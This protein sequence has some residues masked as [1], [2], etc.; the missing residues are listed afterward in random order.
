MGAVDRHL[1]RRCDLELLSS[2][3]SE[4]W[5]K[6]LMNDTRGVLGRALTGHDVSIYTDRIGD[7]VNPLHLK[8]A[9]D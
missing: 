3:E 9:I 7:M 6:I 8:Q 1:F 4:E 2:P 5:N